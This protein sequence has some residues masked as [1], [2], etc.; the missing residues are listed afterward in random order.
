LHE[1]TLLEGGIDASSIAP[2][3][4]LRSRSFCQAH[5]LRS[6]RLSAANPCCAP[7]DRDGWIFPPP[8]T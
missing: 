7:R 3:S 6:R 5:C 2:L 4:A 8:P 1:I